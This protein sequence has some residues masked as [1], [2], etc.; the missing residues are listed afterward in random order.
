MNC[1]C[2]LVVKNKDVKKV[3]TVLEEKKLSNKYLKIRPYK[4]GL[5]QSIIPSS[6]RC[7]TFLNASLATGTVHLDVSNVLNVL[8]IDAQSPVTNLIE[9]VVAVEVPEDFKPMSAFET[10]I[11]QALEAAQCQPLPCPVTELIDILPKSYSIYS[12]MLLLPFHTFRNPHWQ[13]IVSMLDADAERKKAFFS[14]LATQIAVSH[15]AINAIIPAWSTLAE[16]EDSLENILRSPTNL[17]PI[18][19]DFGNS[20]PAYPQHIPFSTD[21]AEAFWVI[22]KQNKIHQ[23]WAPRYTMF[24]AGNVTEKARLLTLPSVTAAIELGNQT[25][26]GCTAVDLFAGIGYFAF[27]YVKAG[28][29]KVLCWDLNPWSIEGLKRGAG[30]NQYGAQVLDFERDLESVDTQ[31][32][33]VYERVMPAVQDPSVKLIA[34]RE[35]NQNAWSRIKRFRHALPPIRHVNCGTLPTIGAAWKIATE[36]L[37]SKLGGHIH[38]HETCPENETT[39]RANHYVELILQYAKT[40]RRGNNTKVELE[41]IETV[42][43]IGPRLLHVVFDIRIDFHT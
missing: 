43:S 42:K 14:A 11:L 30:M 27:S 8:G 19:G 22:T 31:R 21:Y 2:G 1:V 25:G 24:S 18:Y 35:R 15:I 16:H 37:D 6:L 5:D 17:Q 12:P 13:A 4:E 36:A 9:D 7:G 28:C 38:L 39:Q 41:H 32:Q 40:L 26:R 33:S 34:F 10:G 23:C 29:A 3:K 20:L